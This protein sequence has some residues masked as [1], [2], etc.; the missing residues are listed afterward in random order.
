MRYC[1]PFSSANTHL[2]VNVFAYDY[3]GYG[4]SSGRPSAAQTYADAEACLKHVVKKYCISHINH[5]HEHLP[6]HLR[7]TAHV[8]YLVLFL[9]HGQCNRFM[10]LYICVCSYAPKKII[11]YGQSLGSGL[12]IYLG[13]KFPEYVDGIVL[14]SAILSGLRVLNKVW[15]KPKALTS[16]STSTSTWSF[17]HCVIFYRVSVNLYCSLRACVCTF[18]ISVAI[19]CMYALHP[20]I[21]FVYMYICACAFWSGLPRITMV[22]HL[23]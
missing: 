6:A 11:C 7:Q 10:C 9:V 15:S 18:I 22:R 5:D 2:Q 12:S 1:P 3:T 8:P 13:K 19:D 4:Q 17:K 14:H 21:L 23:P 20:I 16:T